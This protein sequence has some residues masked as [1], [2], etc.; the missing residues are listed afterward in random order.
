MTDEPRLL[1]LGQIA[2]A[3]GLRGEVLVRTFTGE[4]EAIGNYGPLVDE[5]GQ[6][7]VELKVVRSTDKGVVVRV[8]G[9][10]DRTGAELLKG[11]KLHVPRDRL[12]AADEGEFYHADLIGLEV[13]G[14]AGEKI[15]WV[16]AVQNYG[17]GDILEIRR[18]GTRQTELL[19][20]TD[21]CVPVVDVAGGHV[22][23]RFPEV[24][25]GEG[26]DE[27]EMELAAADDPGDLDPDTDPTDDP[28][29]N[30]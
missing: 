12:P 20:F 19:A 22:V 16:I 28:R 30:P 5:E 2:G 1:L 24:V 29:S 3:H 15:G 13:R 25:E 11:M 6:R 4:P 21:A 7:S 8:E 23:V 26:G 18:E 27:G 9:V 14:E 10:E 17:A